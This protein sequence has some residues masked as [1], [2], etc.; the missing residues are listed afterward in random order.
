MYRKALVILPAVFGA[1]IASADTY[2]FQPTLPVL[3][4][5][6]HSL[7]AQCHKPGYGAYPECAAIRSQE[8]SAGDAYMKTSPT[9]LIDA[10]G[11]YG[12]GRRELYD[13]T[14]VKGTSSESS[15]LARSALKRFTPPATIGASV[16]PEYEDSDNPVIDSCDEYTYKRY[17]AVNRYLDTINGYLTARRYE[18]AVGAILNGIPGPVQAPGVHPKA[19]APLLN[20]QLVDFEG[21]ASAPFMYGPPHAAF[22]SFKP[23]Y[24]GTRVKNEFFALSDLIAPPA[25]GYIDTNPAH[26]GTYWS[27]FT[28]AYNFSQLN[29]YRNDGPDGEFNRARVGRLD[30]TIR[31]LS[32]AESDDIAVRKIA[33]RRASANVG[34][35]YGRCLMRRMRDLTAIA[36]LGPGTWQDAEQYVADPQQ[37]WTYPV[38]L[39]EVALQMQLFNTSQASGA[40]ST[41]LAADTKSFLQS[42]AW[43]RSKTGSLLLALSKI[44]ANALATAVGATASTIKSLKVPAG[45]DINDEL[46]AVRALV[47]AEWRLPNRG[48]YGGTRCDYN[49]RLFAGDIVS[50]LQAYTYGEDDAKRFCSGTT[51]DDWVNGTATV[52]DQYRHSIGALEGYLHARHAELLEIL[53]TTPHSSSLPGSIGDVRSGGSDWGNGTFGAGYSYRGEWAVNVS[54]KGMVKS[55]L[56]Q[57]VGCSVL[58]GRVDGQLDAYATGFGIRKE[59]IDAGLTAK[60]AQSPAPATLSAHA[61]ILGEDLFTP[62]ENQTL[63]SSYAPADGENTTSFTLATAYVMVGPFPVKISVAVGFDW[64][65]HMKFG[66]TQSA[67]SQKPTLSVGGELAPYAGTNASVSAGVDLFVIGVGVRFTLTLVSASLPF[68]ASVTVGPNPADNNWSVTAKSNLAI[69]L[70]ELAGKVSLFVTSFGITLMDFELFS[71]PGLHQ[72]IDLWH[73]ESTFPF[74]GFSLLGS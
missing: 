26:G 20:S 67:C 27:D 32:V 25:P 63:P 31:T 6:P 42:G 22:D 50:R 45:C 54:S 47:V 73:D 36:N 10:N 72:H 29:A 58:G 46:D 19:C 57:L 37:G 66:Y 24:P 55:S 16:R 52:A 59:L 7:H 39:D 38:D 64:G 30:L 40:L 1:S 44:D 9:T 34:A 49:A 14:K 51:S 13:Q 18:D 41:V 3:V 74:S 65:Y 5:Y 4:P 17:Y 11:Q 70:T 28:A 56:G 2:T 68:D 43:A 8:I 62:I 33:M 71:W 12:T 15:F 35:K 23:N 53:R 61:N 48:C 21:T 60:T 69:D